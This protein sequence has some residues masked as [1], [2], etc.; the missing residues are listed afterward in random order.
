MTDTATP[1]PPFRRIGRTLVFTLFIILAVYILG[2]TLTSVFLALYG[3]PPSLHDGAFTVADRS[4]CVRTL[5]GLRDELEQEVTNVAQPPKPRIDA[6]ARWLAWDATFAERMAEAR[7][8]C[9]QD[10]GME[11]AYDKL[12]QM[13]KGYAAAATHIIAVRTTIAPAVADVVQ[14][15]RGPGEAE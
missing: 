6:Q 14:L 1:S 5:V 7:S 12:G 13:Y 3:K 15:L 4:Y 11:R 2:V 9:T 8:R 10:D